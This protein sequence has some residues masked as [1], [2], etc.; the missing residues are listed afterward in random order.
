MKGNVGHGAS[1]LVRGAKL[2]PHPKLRVF[3][4]VPLVLLG[5]LLFFGAVSTSIDV[6]S[7][8]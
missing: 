7:A 6:L 5:I 1:Y 2:L 4:L 3:V 8:E